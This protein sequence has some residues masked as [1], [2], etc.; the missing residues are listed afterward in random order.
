MSRWHT[1][2]LG[3]DSDAAERLEV[4]LASLDERTVEIIRRRQAAT[5]PVT[6]GWLVR[7][8][9]LTADVI[10]LLLA[11]LVAVL[12][13][14]GVEGHGSTG[15]GMEF[16]LFAVSLPL[17]IVAAKLFG[18]YDKDDARADHSTVD[19][20]A[21]VM[22]L[23]TTG[24][25]VLGL[26]TGYVDPNTT[27][28]LLFWALGVLFV[29]VARAVARLIAR[30]THTYVQNAVIVGAGDVGQ[31]V[32]RKLQQHPEY[33][34]NL[35][36][37]VDDDPR[38]PR[39]DLQ[40]PTV[41]GSPAALPELVRTLHIDRVIVA[42]SHDS[43]E[44]TLPLISSLRQCTVQIDIVP[45]LFE[46][47]G[48]TASV[49]T[50]EGM[51]VVGLPAARIGRSSRM[52]KRAIDIVGASVLLV[53]TAPLFAVA[54]WK[55]RRSSPGPIFF[56]QR[57]LGM[58]QR[59]FTML[60]FRT[61]RPDADEGPHREYIRATMEGEVTPGTNGLFKLDRTAAVTKPGRWLRKS[62]LD[63]LPQLINVLR[64]DMSLVGPRPCLPYEVEHFQPHHFE[65][66]LV[67]AGLTGLWQI[68]A[69]A[70][71]QFGEA[72]EMD[73]VYVRNWS[74]SLDLHL[75][76]RT[77]VQLLRAPATT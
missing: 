33:G 43:A 63:E 7:R 75:L 5:R 2:Q 24:A 42:F 18:L 4:L 34:I 6:R 68:T 46:I 57:R 53:L 36:G 50:L 61:M 59:E 54:A 23:M 22:L 16:L 31:L 3:E 66:F 21:R 1:G 69:R 67:P 48:P 47:V 12:V 27:K 32:A 72:L 38:P 17:W 70:H 71:S 40:H 14:G 49:H 41:L 11:F 30:R 8:L 45:R 37:F 35:V 39:S 65:R 13:A 51:P 56:R 58:N 26:V 15:P 55:I 77:P 20:L 73:V 28:V 44:E 19:E 76:L 25:F 60:K 74:L 9:L 62:S 64:G 29:T 10:G 52:L